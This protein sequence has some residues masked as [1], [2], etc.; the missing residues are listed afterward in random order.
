MKPLD[1]AKNHTASSPDKAPSNA[2]PPLLQS[3][4][5]TLMK[6]GSQGNK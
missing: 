2:L 5:T 6:A 3:L 1:A 4:L